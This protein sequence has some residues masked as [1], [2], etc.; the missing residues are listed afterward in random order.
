MAN[1][2]WW[3]P[4]ELRIT[5]AKSGLHFN[6]AAREAIEE[7]GWTGVRVGILHAGTMV[8]A[9]GSMRLQKPN[10]RTQ[11]CLARRGVVRWLLARG[12]EYGA[13]HAEWLLKPAISETYILVATMSNKL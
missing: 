6:K 2:V 8:V 1:I 13:Y 9:A 10:Q 5:L 11:L 3:P 12:F 4:G 7:A